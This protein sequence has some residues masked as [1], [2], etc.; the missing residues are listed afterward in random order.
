M[1]IKVVSEAF[2]E[3][4]KAYLNDDI[5]NLKKHKIS[6]IR[7]NVT[8]WTKILTTNKKYTKMEPE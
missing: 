2:K 8:K 6:Q 7:K 3:F 5:H 1:Y 4:C